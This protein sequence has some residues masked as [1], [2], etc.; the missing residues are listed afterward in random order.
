MKRLI[1]TS[2]LLSK[3]IIRLN[4]N[5]N[6][7]QLKKVNSRLVLYKEF[8][9]TRYI[10]KGGEEQTPQSQSIPPKG[11][12]DEDILYQQNSI[13]L[14]LRLK[15]AVQCLFNLN[16]V[17]SEL[18]ELHSISGERVFFIWLDLNTNK[19]LEKYHFDAYDFHIGAK[20]AIKQLQLSIASKDFYN[21]INKYSNDNKIN[22][23]MKLTIHPILF[24]GCVDAVKHLH[25][26]NQMIIMK[27]IDIIN[28]NV[29]SL[30]TYIVTSVNEVEEILMINGIEIP[31]KINYPIGSV[32]INCDVTFL[33]N[34]I[35]EYHLENQ[36]KEETKLSKST[37][38]FQACLSNHI[39]MNWI[40]TKF[41]GLGQHD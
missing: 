21:Y 30:E 2:I 19:L 4:S 15:T 16:K 9:S 31:K 29:S 7:N 27:D 41:D 3:H 33:S 13:D 34:C 24:K 18:K 23:F 26:Q 12:I 32:I 40:V 5:I 35:Y 6:I 39:P 14:I 28:A 38:T 11:I 25:E 20:E 22:D 10:L 37:W 1:S 17:S 36:I 8:V